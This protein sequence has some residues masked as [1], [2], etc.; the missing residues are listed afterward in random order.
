MTFENNPQAPQ[1]EA[2][3]DAVMTRRGFIELGSTLAIAVGGIATVGIVGG[4][5]PHHAGR[6][7][8]EPVEAARQPKPGK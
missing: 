3:A 6:P 1:P 8:T 2:E 4:R 5:N 7:D